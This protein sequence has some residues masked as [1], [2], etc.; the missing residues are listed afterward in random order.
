[1]IYGFRG[2]LCLPPDV[3]KKIP[4]QTGITGKEEKYPKCGNRMAR[5]GSYHHPGIVEK[6]KGK[7]DQYNRT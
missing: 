4:H 1:V 2:I 3:V 7:V 5:E 6:K